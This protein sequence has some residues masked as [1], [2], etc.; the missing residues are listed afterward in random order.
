MKQAKAILR[1]VVEVSAFLLAA[2]LML[3]AA[4]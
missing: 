1:W 2:V 3:R 4:M